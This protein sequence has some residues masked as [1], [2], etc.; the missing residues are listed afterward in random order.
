MLELIRGRVGGVVFAAFYRGF[1]KDNERIDFIGLFYIGL[2]FG[3]S[4][5]IESPPLECIR[6]IRWRVVGIKCRLVA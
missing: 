5:L 2:I 4:L 1:R 3:I 6:P